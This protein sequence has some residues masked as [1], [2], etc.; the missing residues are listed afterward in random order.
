MAPTTAITLISECSLDITHWQ[1]EKDLGHLEKSK[2]SLD[3]QR[4]KYCDDWLT[5]DSQ[6]RNG[7]FFEA[8]LIK[9]LS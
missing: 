9:M 2:I 6:G 8:P 1:K 5:P 7:Q 3:P 4:K